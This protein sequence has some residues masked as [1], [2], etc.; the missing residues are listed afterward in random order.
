VGIIA[1]EGDKVVFKR[2]AEQLKA[3]VK[4]SMLYVAHGTGHMIH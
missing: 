3:A 2:R 4:G 1:G